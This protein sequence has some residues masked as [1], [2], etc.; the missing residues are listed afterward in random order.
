MIASFTPYRGGQFI[1]I[2]LLTGR[3]YV[4]CT[5]HVHG[6]LNPRHPLTGLST[7][8]DAD[9][10]A[11]RLII[12][13]LTGGTFLLRGPSSDVDVLHGKSF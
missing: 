9:G 4:N 1:C 12:Q 6:L 8:L 11:R 5:I 3:A 2:V 7:S 13:G 10:D